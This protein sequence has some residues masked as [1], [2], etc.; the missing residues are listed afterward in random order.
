[1]VVRR[2][3]RRP[4]RRRHRRQH[5]DRHRPGAPGQEDA[6]QP[7][8]RQ[9]T[10]GQRCP[11]R[12]RSRRWPSTSSSSTT[13]WTC[14]PVSRSSPTRSCSIGTNLEV[15]ES[16]LTGESD[17]VVKQPGDELLVGQLRRRRQ[18]SGRGRQGRRRRLRRQARRGGAQVHAR[19]QRAARRRSTAS[20]PLVT[21]LLVP[22][23]IGL[24]ISQL[25]SSRTGIRDGLV[26]AVGGVVAMVPEGLILL[27]S[28]AFTVGV[29]RL[30]R[31]ARWC[32]SSPRSRCSPASTSSAS[33]RPARSRPA[34]W[35]SPTSTSS[36]TD[37]TRDDVEHG[38][39]RDRLVRPEPERDPEGAAG[40]VPGPP[41]WTTTGSVA[42]SSARKWSASSFGGH[43]TW[44]FGAPE[45]VLADERYRRRSPTGVDAAADAGKRVLLLAVELRRELSGEDACPTTSTRRRW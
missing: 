4:V 1:M 16:L 13:S 27:T 20:S 3:P 15:D 42:F 34:R 28:V 8:R 17:P 23:G 12:R 40:A 5:A 37:S 14:S 25:D 39:R 29:V 2:V 7:R 10:E 31:S 24:F 36:T 43:G 11:R 26:S 32:R 45:M 41:G 33:T 44:V 21:W 6:R 38:A 9:R 35:T 22:T 18:R 19:A 30:A